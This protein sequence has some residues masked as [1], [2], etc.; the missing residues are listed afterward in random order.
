[1]KERMMLRM[2]INTLFPPDQS[3]SVVKDLDT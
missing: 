3:A 2:A 1:M